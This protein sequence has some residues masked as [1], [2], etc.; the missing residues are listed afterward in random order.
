LITFLGPLFCTYS[1][2]K[3]QK[4]KIKR[5]RKR[6]KKVTRVYDSIPYRDI[7]LNEFF[8]LQYTLNWMKRSTIQKGE[9]DTQT[10][11]YSR[12]RS[13]KKQG[14]RFRV[15]G[16]AHR[17]TSPENSMNRDIGMLH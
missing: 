16:K 15:M 6:K 3:Q 14:I 10:G 7:M 12:Y 11:R 8:T 2:Q 9:R 1:F 13:E 5:K 4:K 17:I